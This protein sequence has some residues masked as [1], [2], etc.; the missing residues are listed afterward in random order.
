MFKSTLSSLG[1]NKAEVSFSVRERDID[2]F[3]FPEYVQT[4]RKH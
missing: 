2:N 1:L 4:L 3:N